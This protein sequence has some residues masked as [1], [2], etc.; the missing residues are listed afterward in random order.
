MEF[1]SNY[2]SNKKK[3]STEVS[4]TQWNSAPGVQLQEHNRTSYETLEGGVA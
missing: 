2:F 3:T 4:L 1:G